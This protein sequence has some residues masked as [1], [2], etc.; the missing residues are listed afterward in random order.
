M[1]LET[2][3]NKEHH[4]AF[5]AIVPCGFRANNKELESKNAWKMAFFFHFSCGQNRKSRSLVFLLLRNQT[6]T[7]A[8]QA[9]HHIMSL[10]SSQFS[11][12]GTDRLVFACN[13]SIY[14]VQHFMAASGPC[15]AF[16]SYIFPQI[17]IPLFFY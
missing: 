15:L 1:Q 2:N 6:E 5:V 16:V 7:L 11:E 10:V 9:K 8:T 13:S 4:L 17:S 3:N 12:A 14:L